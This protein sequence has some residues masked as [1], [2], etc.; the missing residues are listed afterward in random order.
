VTSAASRA[1]ALSGSLPNRVTPAPFVRQHI[2]DPFEHR[3]AL[4]L[5]PPAAEES[6][7]PPTITAPLGK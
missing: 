1:A 7:P 4:R 2:P 6:S 3:K 5:R